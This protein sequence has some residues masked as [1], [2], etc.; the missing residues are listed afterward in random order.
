MLRDRYLT[1]SIIDDL[2]A[3]MVFVGG[4]RQVGKTTLAKVFIGTRFKETAY[5]NW[6]NKQERRQVMAAEWAGSAELLILDEIHKFRGWKR[7]IKGEYDVHKDRYRFMVTGSVR[8]D[9]YRKGGD[10]LQG[11]Y[12]YYR[13]HPFTLA[14]LVKEHRPVEPFKE[15][16]V[17]AARRQE[18]L[19][20]ERFGGFPEP[21]FSQ[22]ERVLRRWHGERN[23]RL[24]REDIR[25][26]EIVRELS[27]MQVLSDMLP[28]KVGGL[29]SINSMREDLEVS[30]GAVS[31]W[32]NIL[33]EFYYHFR[34]YPFAR[35]SFRALKKEPKLYLWDWSEVPDEAA[36]F[37]NLVGSHLLKLVHW[38]RD[39]EGFKAGLYF[40]RDT[41]KREVDFLV[42]M[43]EKPWF[44]VEVKLNDD[45]LAPNL[46]YFRDKLN[47]PFA[48]QA[49]KKS[50]VDRMSD[51]IRVISADKLLSALI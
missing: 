27:K 6:D 25:D 3:K 5:F 1:S 31:H 39:R 8:L 49:L 46:R 29:L 41:S 10:S 4:P 24:F 22:N 43:E 42:T 11:R 51:G 47:I 34:V 18:L 33:E 7:F 32:L 9:I 16:P 50:G 36:R 40:L 2:K 12:H 15:P 28:S 45:G 23:E 48:Y 30:H 19:A 14:E 26:I 38:L 37:E 21:L 20:L 35:A 17:G 44:A 13:L